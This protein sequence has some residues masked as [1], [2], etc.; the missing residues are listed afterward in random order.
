MG[1]SW[2]DRA[3]G[4][5]NDIVIDKNRVFVS[6]AHTCSCP[7]STAWTATCETG[8]V[9]N[10]SSVVTPVGR[11]GHSQIQR[12]FVSRRNRI[13]ACALS[14][15]RAD[16]AASPRVPSAVARRWRFVGYAHAST[17]LN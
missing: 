2:Q 16:H 14:V 5:A 10:H 3:N 12:R 4:V 17:S 6:T 13:R 8:H 1:A 11:G 15:D 7:R 9:Q